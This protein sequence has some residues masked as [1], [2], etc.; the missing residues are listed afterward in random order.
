MVEEP[1]GDKGEP[2]GSA[3]PATGRL[4]LFN[5]KTTNKE[6][7]LK[8][9]SPPTHGEKPYAPRRH[10]VSKTDLKEISSYANGTFVELSGFSRNEPLAPTHNIVHRPDMPPQAFYY[11]R[12]TVKAGRP[13]RGIV[14]NRAKPRTTIITQLVTCWYASNPCA[15]RCE[16]RKLCTER[17]TRTRGSR[18]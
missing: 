18:S 6:P 13:W 12:R 2:S 5:A 3:L 9:N 8:I 15:R 17:L 4:F 10:L 16:R 7:A 1:P 14:M 11:L